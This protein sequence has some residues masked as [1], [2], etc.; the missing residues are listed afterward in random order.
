MRLMLKAVSDRCGARLNMSRQERLIATSG[1]MLTGFVYCLSEPSDPISTN[2][3][4]PNPRFVQMT[5]YLDP[6]IPLDSLFKHQ[7][8]PLHIPVLTDEQMEQVAMET[9]WTLATKFPSFPSSTLS[10]LVKSVKE[11]ALSQQEN[12]TELACPLFESDLVEMEA[13]FLL[14]TAPGEAN[15]IRYHNFGCKED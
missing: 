14:N 9:D 3:V 2:N 7:E 4:G 10:A 15:D 12:T 11:S 6:R 8:T 5:E 13:L 1:N